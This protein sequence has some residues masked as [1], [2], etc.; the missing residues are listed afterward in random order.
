MPRWQSPKTPRIVFGV[1]HS[2][3][4]QLLGNIPVR[5]VEMGWDV[6]V[7]ARNNG[8][9]LPETFDQVSF[10]NLPM[11][12][13]PSPLWDIYL[14]LHWIFLLAKIRPEIVSIGTP[15]AGMLGILAA[16]ICRVRV[17][18]YHLRGLRLE[19][20]VGL[21]KRIL[22]LSEWVSSRSA[23]HILAV[24]ESLKRAY[25]AIGL[26]SSSKIAVVGLGSSHGVDIDR[27][28]PGRWSHWEPV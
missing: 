16:L 18:V 22:Y 7:V 4:L 17:R 25:C 27:F 10:H 3:S 14:L 6:H 28:K 26:A 24:S 12:R 23:T 13:K 11:V 2:Q 21:K 19:T 15:K 1:T 8:H 5:L 9:P 20:E